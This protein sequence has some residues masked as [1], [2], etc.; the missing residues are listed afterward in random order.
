MA[1]AGLY[2]EEQGLVLLTYF[3]IF[4]KNLSVYL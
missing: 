2:L 1:S 4:L 3:Q